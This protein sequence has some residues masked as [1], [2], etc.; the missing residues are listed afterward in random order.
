MGQLIGS[1]FTIGNT[2]YLA[3]ANQKSNSFNIPSNIYRFDETQPLGSQFVLVQQVSTNGA[4]DWEFFTIGNTS[5]LAVA[6][7]YNGKSWIISSDIYRF[8]QTQPLGSQLVLVQ[9]IST[10]GA[11]DWEFFTI[12][13]TSYLA[14][15]NYY[16]GNSYN[17][18]SDIYGLVDLCWA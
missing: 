18:P 8:D 13:N 1:F 3:V 12:N 2:S 4:V 9:Q 5:Y 14:V 6:N 11:A 10:I 15:A 16:N 7:Y 17:I